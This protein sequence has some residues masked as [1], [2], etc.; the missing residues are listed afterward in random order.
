MLKR[1]RLDA[2]CFCA[3]LS[4]SP[5]VYTTNTIHSADGTIDRSADATKKGPFSGPAP[6]N[7]HKLGPKANTGAINAGLRALDR[8]GKP[9]RKWVRKGFQ[10]KSFTGFQWDAGSWAA[11][12]R[13]SSTFSGD[14]KSDSSTTEDVK[15]NMDSSAV[16][17]RSGSGMEVDG[18]KQSNGPESSPAPAGTP[19]AA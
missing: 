9:C 3:W 5:S 4:S 2:F 1:R 19:I 7:T 11:P 10:C 15:A 16:S 14:V 18:P 8:T 6:I 12:A 17:E 13:S